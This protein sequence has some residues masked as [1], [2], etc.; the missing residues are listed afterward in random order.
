MA[1]PTAVAITRL[2]PKNHDEHIHFDNISSK[3]RLYH[4][5]L[6]ELQQRAVLFNRNTAFQ[7][8]VLWRIVLENV[9]QL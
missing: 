9:W 4:C 6:Y 3:F 5:K 7:L 2:F 8:T 1:V